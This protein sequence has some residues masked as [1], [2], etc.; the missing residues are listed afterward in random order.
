[1]DKVITPEDIKIMVERKTGLIDISKKTRI[2]KYTCARYTTVAL[3]KDFV[4]RKERTHE[5]LA[6]LVGFK[7][8]CN[9]NHA[10]ITFN[11]NFNQNWFSEYRDL[12]IRCAKE[13]LNYK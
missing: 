4:T 11:E 8:Q 9:C 7:N 6:K 5:I 10:H 2:P 3:C 1:M 12:Y 13:I